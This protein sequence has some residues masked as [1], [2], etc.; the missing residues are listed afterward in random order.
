M[1]PPLSQRRL[2]SEFAGKSSSGRCRTSTKTESS[3]WTRGFNWSSSKDT[4]SWR[5][6]KCRS[7]RGKLSIQVTLTTKYI[8]TYLLGSMYVFHLLVICDI[9]NVTQ[10]KN[11]S[12]S[13]RGLICDFNIHVHDHLEMRKIGNRKLLIADINKHVFNSI[14]W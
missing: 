3:A 14:Y 2:A 6:R 13:S 10:Y 4:I 12:P 8:F 9:S 5:I 11:T 1:N 7:H